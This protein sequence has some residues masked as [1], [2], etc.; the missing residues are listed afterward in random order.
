MANGVS[1]R[2]MLRFFFLWAL[3]ASFG[4]ISSLDRES[5]KKESI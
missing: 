5:P 1:L 4:V 2:C 3:L